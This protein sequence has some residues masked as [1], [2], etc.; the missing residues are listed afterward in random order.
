[1][2]V[3][4]VLRVGL[5]AQGLAFGGIKTKGLRAAQKL[6]ARL[7]QLL[8]LLA[9]QLLRKL[10]HVLLQV[11]GR[12]VEDLGALANGQLAPAIKGF[13]RRLHGR[14]GVRRARCLKTP[15][16]IAG[17]GGVEVVKG[18]A[19]QAGHPGAVDIVQK[20]LHGVSHGGEV[21]ER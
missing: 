14:L 10:L 18:A 1:M 12:V 15:H 11:A 2:Q 20:R 5:A 21:L 13:L 19:Q 7:A 3:G 6:V 9:G 4:I 17:I 8:A 16:H